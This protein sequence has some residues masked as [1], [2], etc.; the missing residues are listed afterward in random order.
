MPL[1]ILNVRPTPTPDDLV[2]YFHRTEL[3]YTQPLGE[4]TQLDAG[5][6]FTNPELPDVYDANR[7][8]DASLPEGTSP[9]DAFAEV[10][11]H[12]AGK[13]TRCWRWTLNSSAA[14]GDTEPLR[15]YLLSR[16][17][18][19]D[20]V[21]VLYLAGMPTGPIAEA[22]GLTI[23]P[24]RAS[25]RHA[26]QLAGEGAARLAC[27][28]L[29]EA[30]MLHLDDSHWDCLL[31]LRDGQPLATI[32]V[33]AVG[34][35]GRIEGLYVSE[36]ARRQGIGRTMLARAM[37]IC[38]RSLFKHVFLTCAP[39]NAAAQALYQQLGFQ[40]LATVTSYGPP[41]ARVV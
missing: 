41:D 38:A 5:T 21:D 10:E 14:P 37:E 7:I 20:P 24:A 1:P 6:A 32:G 18:V 34:E 23:I 9:P 36:S 33:L 39:D 12:F 27:P 40:K 16:G 11:S 8:L 29:A 3:H 22:G 17:Y 15:E 28:N 13:G 25:F 2:R 30:Q 35:L 26:R 31:A 4:E 19:P